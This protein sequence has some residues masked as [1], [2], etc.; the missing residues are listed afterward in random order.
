MRIPDLHIHPDFSFDAQ[1]SIAQYAQAASDMGLEE[2]CF[3]TH[4]DLDPV[5]READGWVNVDGDRFPND[6]PAWLVPYLEQIEQA[7]CQKSG[8]RIKCGLEIDWFPE[9]EGALAPFLSAFP[10]DYLLGSVHCLEHLAVAEHAQG[11][12]YL[13]RHTPAETAVA[14]AE[15]TLAAIR[16]GKFTAIAHL[17]YLKRL[18]VPGFRRSYHAALADRLEEVFRA[19]AETDTALEINTRAINTYGLGE[20]FPGR[21]ALQQA[22]RCGVRQIAFGSDSH[23]PAEL[24]NSFPQAMEF[25]I[26]AG[27]GSVTTY[28]GGRIERIIPLE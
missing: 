10:W 2:I 15:C 17:D 12:A 21:E 14:T 1:G 9:V 23:R 8:L 13:S 24:A 5:R 28:Q 26:Q 19:L 25:A 4:L 27:F 18:D 11:T 3:T 20:P 22:F 6:D 16:S 7:R